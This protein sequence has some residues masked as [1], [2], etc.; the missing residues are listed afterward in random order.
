M[1]VYVCLS[2]YL[3]HVCIVYCIVF[4]NLEFGNLSNL[5]IGNITK[6]E[7]HII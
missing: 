1:E 3:Y 6:I 4:K 2:L 7:K 5:S